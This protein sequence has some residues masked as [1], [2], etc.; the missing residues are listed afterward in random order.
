MA[1]VLHEISSFVEIFGALAKKLHLLI[2]LTCLPLKIA[3]IHIFLNL[4]VF[5]SFEV[6]RNSINGID[7][8]KRDRLVEI[9]I[10]READAD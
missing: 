4:P 1:Q 2:F 5:S 7:R 3:P 6:L 8:F 10:D 9:T